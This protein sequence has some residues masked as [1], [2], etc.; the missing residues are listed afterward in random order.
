MSVEIDTLTRRV[1]GRHGGPEQVLLNGVSLSI[2]EGAFVALVGPS[3]AGKTTLLRAIAG[4]DTFQSGHVLV[5]GRAL[6]T[7]PPRE[8]GVGF[9]FQNYA[10]F[11][12]M[13][14]AKN[15]SFGLNV[16]PRGQRPSA[17]DINTRVEELL[18]LIELPALGGAYPRQI[19]GGQRQR[20]ALARAL[21]TRPSLLLLDE[22]F[23]ALDPVVRRRVR[24]W[25]RSLHDKLGLTSLLVTHDHEEALDVAD[26]LVVMQNG[27]VVQTGDADTLE[28]FPQTSFVMDFLGETIRFSGKCQNINGTMTFLPDEENILPFPLDVPEGQAEAILRPWEI[29]L[30][31]GQGSAASR[32]L[33][34]RSGLARLEVRLSGSESGRV[35]EILSARRE[36]ET[37]EGAAL[38]ISAA[39]VFRDDLLLKAPAG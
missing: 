1:P 24:A 19:S 39:R 11:G 32:V 9:V 6:D 14:V 22:P 26:I 38:D 33:G 20:V 29:R 30:L 3:G 35:I 5:G 21:A 13:T 7:L 25:V 23:G 36:D 15:I 28:R 31:A 16:M 4:L 37:I 18:A 8:R 27:N 2:P 17:E 10:L 12:H 34:H